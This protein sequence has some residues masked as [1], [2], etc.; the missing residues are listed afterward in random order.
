VWERF[1][2][3]SLEKRKEVRWLFFPSY[4]G[5]K[6]EEIKIHEEGGRGHRKIQ[7]DY[8]KKKLPKRN[9]FFISKR[10]KEEKVSNHLSKKRKGKRSGQCDQG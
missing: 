9:R 2:W 3:S 4:E 6:G 1:G 10:R 5:G 7:V 8:S